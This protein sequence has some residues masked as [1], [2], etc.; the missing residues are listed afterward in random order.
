M[1]LTVSSGRRSLGYR[2]RILGS[3][4]V[5]Q[6]LELIFLEANFD[7]GPLGFLRN[8]MFHWFLVQFLVTKAWDLVVRVNVRTGV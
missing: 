4:G 2:G 7:K 3:G 8:H 6:G 1:K 5:L